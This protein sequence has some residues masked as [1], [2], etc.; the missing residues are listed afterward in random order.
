MKRNVTIALG[1]FLVLTLLTAGGIVLLL[2]GMEKTPK[3]VKV[4]GEG[5]SSVLDGFT[6]ETAFSV[7]H[8]TYGNAFINSYDTMLGKRVQSVTFMEGQATATEVFDTEEC[9]SM[10]LYQWLY[11][12]YSYWENA[13]TEYVFSPDGKTE[14][15]YPMD[16]LLTGFRGR[17]VVAVSEE[18]IVALIGTQEENVVVFLYD[19]E[20]ATM[21]KS[22][23][24][25]GVGKIGNWGCSIDGGQVT[26][27]INTQDK[28][29]L[30]VFHVKEP[31]R[32]L[33]AYEI[34]DR[35]V[36]REYRGSESVT[37]Q[38][39][40]FHD[41]DVYV[42][43]DRIY[44]AEFSSILEEDFIRYSVYVGERGET[45]YQGEVYLEEKRVLRNPKWNPEYE[46]KAEYG[47]IRIISKQ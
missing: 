46:L 35:G 25:E 19:T 30:A 26:L 28:S 43:G 20:T 12:N 1:T 27:R 39:T 17:G 23:L 38:G 7:H 22:V 36:I 40:V 37:K 33:Y 21:K 10:E 29:R 14:Y 24:W 16:T 4:I 15:R 47:R 42:D 34:N 3:T 6:V 2:F 32:M 9:G 11:R 45:L 18:N 41:A 8:R 44:I 13:E 5:D 31:E